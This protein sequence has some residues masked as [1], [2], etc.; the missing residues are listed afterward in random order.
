MEAV[1]AG[2]L[3]RVMTTMVGV[4]MR[5][6]GF[7]GKKSAAVQVKR[8]ERPKRHISQQLWRSASVDKAEARA[9]ATFTFDAR[10]T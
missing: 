10:I 5:R 2:T 6:D 8:L 9:Q 7:E 4:T 3:D 1:E